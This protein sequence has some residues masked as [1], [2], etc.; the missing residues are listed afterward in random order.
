MPKI[1]ATIG[2]IIS[3]NE[4]IIPRGDTEIKAND[5]L[6]L[7]SSAASEAEAITLITGK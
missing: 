5:M 4:N 7:L 6:L 2:C 3:S 1:G